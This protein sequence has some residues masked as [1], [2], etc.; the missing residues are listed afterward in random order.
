MYLIQFFLSSC[1]RYI[2]SATFKIV[3][4]ESDIINISNLLR[5]GQWQKYGLNIFL[6]IA[7]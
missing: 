1:A 7:A 5:L 3:C 2:N 6:L 4:L